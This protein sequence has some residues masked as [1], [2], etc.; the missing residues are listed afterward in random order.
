MWP[1]AVFSEAKLFKDLGP[2]SVSGRLTFEEM[3]GG[4]AR[5]AIQSRRVKGPPT[6]AVAEFDRN[7]VRVR[8][9]WFLPAAVDQCLKSSPAATTL[10]VA[11]P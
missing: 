10:T 8:L 1:P 11:W 4:S 6:I 3:L 9:F 5:A 2:K 7:A